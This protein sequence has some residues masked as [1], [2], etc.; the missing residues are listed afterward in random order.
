MGR[1]RDGVR[2]GW[3]AGGIRSLSAVW[4]RGGAKSDPTL[5]GRLRTLEG[6]GV[7]PRGLQLAHRS[8]WHAMW[9]G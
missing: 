3:G 6:C 4:G 2:E 7:Q 5:N 9:W 8:L 1:G